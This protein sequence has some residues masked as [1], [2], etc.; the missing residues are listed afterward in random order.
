MLKPNLI[1]KVKGFVNIK[2]PKITCKGKKIIMFL[3][4]FQIR[5]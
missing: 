2:R 3:F 4:V 5:K 1:Q